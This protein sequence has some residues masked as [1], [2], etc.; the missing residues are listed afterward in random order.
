MTKIHIKNRKNNTN[1][2]NIVKNI[3]KRIIR[4]GELNY[5]S[6]II[7]TMSSPTSEVVLLPPMS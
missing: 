1:E 5:S 6:F 7:L 4:K 2:K 3:V